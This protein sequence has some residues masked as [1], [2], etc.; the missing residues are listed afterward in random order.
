[1]DRILPATPTHSVSLGESA[2]LLELVAFDVDRKAKWME[3]ASSRWIDHRRV[4]T[5]PAQIQP[6]LFIGIS[7]S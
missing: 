2:E 4:A 5:L 1:V 6:S 7:I 3:A